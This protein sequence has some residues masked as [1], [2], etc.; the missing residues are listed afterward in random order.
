MMR[1]CCFSGA[2]T[3]NLWNGAAISQTGRLPKKHRGNDS[4]INNRNLRDILKN[5]GVQVQYFEV[6]EGHSWGHW[7]ALLDDLLIFFYGK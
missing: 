5:K 1:T 4:A 6:P 3:L 2:A 7:R